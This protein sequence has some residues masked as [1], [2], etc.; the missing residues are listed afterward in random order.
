MKRKIPIAMQSVIAAT[1]TPEIKSLMSGGV[2]CEGRK[3]HAWPPTG[4]L[5]ALITHQFIVAREPETSTALPLAAT[6]RHAIQ[7]SQSADLGT[8]KAVR[9][10]SFVIR[11]RSW[12]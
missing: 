8:A 10:A 9:L 1:G 7:F 6:L 11:L 3:F 4:C 12:R 5:G 2:A